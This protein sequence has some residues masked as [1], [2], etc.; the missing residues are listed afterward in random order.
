MRGIRASSFLPRRCRWEAR[1][2]AVIAVQLRHD[3]VRLLVDEG[4]G[5]LCNIRAEYD[6][7][8]APT[9]EMT[10]PLLAASVNPMLTLTWLTAMIGFIVACD[11]MRPRSTKLAPRRLAAAIAPSGSFLKYASISACLTCAR[12]SSGVNVRRPSE[13]RRPLIAWK[14][15][16]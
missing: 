9:S 6:W 10:F 7:V 2:P 13:R 11:E 8:L 12:I 14:C 15:G 16:P 4:S 5:H 1:I 3:L